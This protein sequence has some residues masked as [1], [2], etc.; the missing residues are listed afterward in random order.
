MVLPAA[1][2]LG[3][4]GFFFTGTIFFTGAA[5]FADGLAEGAVFFLVTVSG[6]FFAAA[7][8]PAF[9]AALF[10]PGTAFAMNLHHEGLS[11]CRMWEK[12][13]YWKMDDTIS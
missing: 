3:V 9:F 7:G 1:F 6:F 8:L 4:A 5:F 10:F 13:H 2:F 11:P 12:P